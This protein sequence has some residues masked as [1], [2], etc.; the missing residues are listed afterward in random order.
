MWLKTTSLGIAGNHNSI[1]PL[2]RAHSEL[3]ILTS[4]LN[5]GYPGSWFLSFSPSST[6]EEAGIRGFR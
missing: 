4:S 1:S 6:E 5:L 3:F 2:L